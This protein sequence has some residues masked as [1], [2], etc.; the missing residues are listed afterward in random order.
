MENT[1]STKDKTT[2]PC[3]KTTK[4]LLKGLARKDESWDAF[5]NRVAQ[6]LENNK[7]DVEQAINAINSGH[8]VTHPCLEG[9]LI[10]KYQSCDALH[11]IVH[12]WN[13]RD[14]P[15]HEKDVYYKEYISQIEIVDKNGMSLGMGG[16]EVNWVN[17]SDKSLILKNGWD[18][19][20][21][22]D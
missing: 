18:I 2:I 19:V 5:L 13:E 16:V 14:D 22:L 11:G 15:N 20:E 6:T 8:V 10:R 12:G 4:A 7:I 21:R 17:D 1:E 3:R 9:K